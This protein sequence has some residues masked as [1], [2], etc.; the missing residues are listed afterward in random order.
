M[1]GRRAAA[2]ALGVVAIL[3]VAAVGAYAVLSA[4]KKGMVQIFVTDSVGQWAHVNVT[5]D[6]IKVHRANGTNDSGWVSIPIKNGTLD[7]AKLVD[8]SALLGEGKVPV[9][10]YTQ[11]RI[12]VVN[13]TGMMTNG[14]EVDFKVPSGELRTTTPFSVNSGETTKLTLDIDLDSSITHPDGKWIFKPV[15]GKITQG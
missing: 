6:T 1:S 15:L 8:V 14:T 11:L 13:A 10:K 7:L 3:I 9:G 4:P 2:I 12:V 5:F